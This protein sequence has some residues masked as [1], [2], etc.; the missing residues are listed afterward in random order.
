MIKD[1]YIQILI[2]TKYYSVLWYNFD[3]IYISLL[4]TIICFI[5]KKN[6]LLI[7]QIISILLIYLRYSK[8]YLLDQKNKSPINI[9]LGTIEE[10]IPIAV[11]GF[12]FSYLKLIEKINKFQNKKRI[13]FF[14]LSII[15]FLFKYDIF[16][17]YEGFR[18]P[19]ILLNNFSAIFLFISFLS[20]SLETIKNKKINLLIN[21]I[22]KF[23]GGIYYLHIFI[24]KILKI[25]KIT[26]VFSFF[27]CII[28]YYICFFI[29]LF[30]N[31]LFY[32][33][34]L[35]FLFY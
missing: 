18:Y 34:K 3:L 6:F 1:F 5:F 4:F 15:Y 28:I 14:S 30:G 21:G 16:I 22:T 13:L 26:I 17:K 12:T 10:M 31:S 33:T 27:E 20:I 2:G 9:N 19:D 8:I 24:F 7:L 25:F 29:C 11:T 23:T 32:K 35:K